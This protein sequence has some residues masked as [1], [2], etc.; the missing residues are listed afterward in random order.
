MLFDWQTGKWSQWLTEPDAISFPRWSANSK[1]MIFSSMYP[2]PGFRRIRLGQTKSE[3]FVRTGD[4]KIYHGIW[5][6]WTGLGPND[7][8]TL[9]RD[10]SS[11]E[12]YALEL[13]NPL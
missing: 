8:P 4:L 1:S 10:I 12:I 2:E 3:L 7:T 13:Q 6:A 11:E 9:V 5:G